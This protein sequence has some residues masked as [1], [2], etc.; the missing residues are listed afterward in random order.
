MLK[1]K[2]FEEVLEQAVR[3]IRE[4]EVDAAEASQR[5]L[6]RLLGTSAEQVVDGQI[7]GCPDIQKLLPAYRAGRLTPGREM[8]VQDHLR[9]C[10]AC[11]NEY[12]SPGTRKGVILPWHDTAAPLKQQNTTHLQLA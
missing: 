3:S 5:V 7:N 1:G 9:E 6:D 11:R 10:V 8:L 12:Q 2:N 4:E